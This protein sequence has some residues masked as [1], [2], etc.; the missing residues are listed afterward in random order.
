MLPQIDPNSALLPP[1]KWI[2]STAWDFIKNSKSLHQTVG[3]AAGF[4]AL[5]LAAI[6]TGITAAVMLP[7]ALPLAGAALATLGIT[8]FSGLK[9]RQ[10]LKVFKAET[11]PELQKHVGKKYVEYKM[12]EMRAAWNKKAEERKAQKAAAAKPE[13]PKAEPV[14]EA[15]KPIATPVPAPAND[16][17]PANL[18]NT[19]GNWMLKKALELAAKKQ[20]GKP[21]APA[22]EKDA[23]AQPKPPQP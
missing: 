3:K 5:G 14:V 11:L 1:D 16:E 9:I 7:L 8:A 20:N 6:G 23:K 18:G 21:D 13:T 2:K 17:K 12:S 4:A 22:A 19:L 15:P 10:Q